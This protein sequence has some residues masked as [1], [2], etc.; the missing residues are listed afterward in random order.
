M[1]AAMASFGMTMSAAGSYES[2][3]RRGLAEK[4]PGRRPGSPEPSWRLTEAGLA[5]SARALVIA[6][7]ACGA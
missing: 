5:A 7:R 3:R 6:G 4:V 2:L 1:L